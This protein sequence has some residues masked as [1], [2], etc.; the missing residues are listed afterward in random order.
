MYI[1]VK[2][3]NQWKLYI[4]VFDFIIDST[5]YPP[6]YRG[7]YYNAALGT[8]Y[9]TTQQQQVYQQ[10][11]H[12]SSN[13]LEKKPVVL[14]NT[15]EITKRGQE[16]VGTNQVLKGGDT[17]LKERST[18]DVT[19]P[20]PTVNISSSTVKEITPPDG[21]VPLDSPQNPQSGN[22]GTADD[23]IDKE[24][25]EW[26]SVNRKKKTSKTEGK[27]SLTTVS[28]SLVTISILHIQV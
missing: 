24:E 3:V 2:K 15:S 25:N 23:G 7:Q 14:V 26:T 11:Q 12:V 6:V 9:P 28:K 16:E 4:I 17:S 5:M 13:Q 20:A 21:I 19:S 27:V 22:T 1:L 10:K 18:D 8:Y